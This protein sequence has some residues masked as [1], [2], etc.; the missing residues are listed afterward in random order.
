MKRYAMGALGA[1]NLALAVG[2]AAAWLNPDGSLRNVHW[3][4][5]EP[6]TVDYLTS[7]PLLPARASTDMGRVISMTDRPLFSPTRRPPP[8]PPPTVAPEDVPVD[9][10]S[11]ARILGVYEG[12]G[13][14]GIVVNVAGKNRR[15]RL[16]ESVDGWTLKS[17]Q[18]K[19]VVFERSGQTRTLQLTRALFKGG[20][21]NAP[22][23]PAEFL[24]SS[25]TQVPP[26]APE[27]G[28]KAP[29]PNSNPAAP[30]PSS[31]RRFGP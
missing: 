6:V 1:L 4:Q 11:T 28:V 15:I 19:A 14:G 20:A 3:S 10:L 12:S 29:S 23:L 31:A 22:P 30:S 26:A 13:V 9:N 17:I 2:L 8:P 16:H 5:P 25:P 7:V 27:S 24:P 18:G 21:V